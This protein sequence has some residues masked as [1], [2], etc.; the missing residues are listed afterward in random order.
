VEATALLCDYAEERL[1]KLYI[2]GAGWDTVGANAPTPVAVALIVHVGWDETNKPHNLRVELMTEDGEPVE[3]DGNPV[4][5]EGK[6]ELGRPA[7]TKAGSVF[8]APLAVRFAALALPP[9]G[10]RFEVS[11]D[12]NLLKALP[13]RA[14]GQPALPGG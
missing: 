1:G 3:L 2:M 4:H 8:N 14:L 7:G 5:I 9:G 10:Y 6:M 13:F 11:V 12:T